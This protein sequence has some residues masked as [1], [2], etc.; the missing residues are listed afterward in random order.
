ME[1]VLVKEMA[2]QTEVLLRNVGTTLR[3]CQPGRSLYGQPMWKHVYHMLHSLDQWFIN[4]MKYDEPSFH[5]P[6]L[7]SLDETSDDAFGHGPADGL[8]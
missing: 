7:N 1:R 2:D 3:T 8:L 4:P 6:G 5:R